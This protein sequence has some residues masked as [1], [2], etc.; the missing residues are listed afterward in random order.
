MSYARR[1]LGG[2]MK[3]L[4]LLLFLVMIPV[5]AGSI[6]KTVTFSQTDLVFS[7]VDD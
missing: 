7:K 4:L 1:K 3:K 2:M 5:G 6:T